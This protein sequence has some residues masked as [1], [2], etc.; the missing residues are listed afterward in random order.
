M[1]SVAEDEDDERRGAGE[2][3]ERV[4]G[5]GEAVT[6]TTA[7]PPDTPQRRNLPDS[8]GAVLRPGPSSLLPCSPSCS[9]SPPPPAGCT[10]STAADG[11]GSLQPREPNVT[12]EPCARHEPNLARCRAC[13]PISGPAGLRDGRV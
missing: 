1:E 12:A 4:K 7:V 2:G 13:L 6:V 8:L 3:T 9:P 5:G 11:S 10:L